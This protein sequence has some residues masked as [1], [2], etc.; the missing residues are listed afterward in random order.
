MT[1]WRHIYVMC[2][3]VFTTYSLTI[4]H[5]HSRWI[6]DSIYVWPEW[7]Y[8][9]ITV[10]PHTN[11]VLEFNL[12]KLNGFLI[13]K[14]MGWYGCSLINL[15]ILLLGTSETVNSTPSPCLPCEATC[16]VT[17]TQ[18]TSTTETSPK[19][20]VTTQTTTSK[21]PAT[22]KVNNVKPG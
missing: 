18:Q 10:E 2:I 19:D 5:D 3:H 7:I 13:Y 4:L 1:Q 15:F 12:C 11:T 9:F 6:C 22:T 8:V 16:D 20:V 21:T 17:P 14:L